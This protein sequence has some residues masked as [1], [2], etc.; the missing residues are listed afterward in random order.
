M[1]NVVFECPKCSVKNTVDAARLVSPVRC[2]ACGVASMADRRERYVLLR[3]LGQGAFGIVHVA[4]DTRLNREVALKELKESA[5]PQHEIDTWKLRA[6]NEA[7]TLT[8]LPRHANILEVYDFGYVG[9]KFYMVT[10]III[11]KDL[12]S[13]I[14]PDGFRDP[15]VAVQHAVTILKALEHAHRHGIIHRDIK[16]GNVM[17]DQ[18][19]N[20]L[21]LDFGLAACETVGK[22]DLNEMGTVLGTPAYM[23]PEQARGE[24]D[25]IGT[26]SDQYSA[27]AVLY[28]MLTGKVPYAG[29]GYMTLAEVGNR[30]KQPIPPSRYRTDL[31]PE[32][33]DLILTALAKEP[34]DRFESCHEFAGE[35]TK[36]SK[37]RTSS[38]GHK[39]AV[40]VASP[41]W[42][43]RA[44]ILSG[45]VLLATILATVGY[46]VANRNPKAAPELGTKNPTR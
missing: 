9:G 20:L 7:K 30:Q 28:K 38:S 19:G 12:D 17:M 32:L 29:K 21:L 39:P 33:E 11:G 24:I 27:A 25:Q 15:H 40:P 43:K 16:P 22:R 34:E 35:L 44:G 5:I 2:A 8:T 4:Y 13:I 36:W 10:P 31:D 23:P 6:L 37:D 45:A 14:P 41:A 42:K 26:W 18:G 46:V 1:S 3:K